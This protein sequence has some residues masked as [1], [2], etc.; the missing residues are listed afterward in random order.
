MNEK[1]KKRRDELRKKNKKN[2]DLFAIIISLFIVIGIIALSLGYYLTTPADKN[3]KE[4][5]TVEIKESYGTSAVADVLAQ[6]GLIKNETMFK[7]YSKLSSKNEF[8]VGKYQIN[9][10]MSVSEIL[11]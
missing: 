5:I 1:L 9:K 6:Q 3:D 10:S 8:Y 2:S 7:L 4:Q 11:E